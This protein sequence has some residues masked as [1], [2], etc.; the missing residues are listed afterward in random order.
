M[1]FGRGLG[2]FSV[3]KVNVSIQTQKTRSALMLSNSNS[4]LGTPSQVQN[5]ALA[6]VKFHMLGDCTALWSIQGSPCKA[7]LPS[8][9]SIA[10]PIFLKYYF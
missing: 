5:E 8:M 3:A 9:E 2:C 7:S 6:L 4:N 10:S 1:S